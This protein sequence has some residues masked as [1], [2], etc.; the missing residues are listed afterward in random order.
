MKL[1]LDG[2]FFVDGGFAG[3]NQLGTWDQVVAARETFLALA[4]M[5]R[6]VRDTAA[7]SRVENSRTC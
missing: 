7:A 5:A 3:P 1:T 6:E 4:V 2:V